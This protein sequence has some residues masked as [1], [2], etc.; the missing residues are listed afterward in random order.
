MQEIA[1]RL[2]RRLL[3]IGVE[4]DDTADVRL[5]KGMLMGFS[6]MVIPAGFI[7]GFIYIYFNEPVA[8]IFPLI[9]GCMTI[10]SIAIYALTG[11]YYRF[12]FVQ[13]LM[14]LVLPFLLLLA[15]GGFIN[16]SAVIVWSFIS[17]LG[18]LVFS[19]RRWALRWFIA[20]IAVVVVSGLLQPYLRPSNNL[21]TWLVYGFFVMN[22]G[23]I[24]VV[25][26]VLF[27]YFIGQKDR[28]LQLLRQEQEKTDTLLLNVL[29][30]E[31]AAILKY[32][33]RLIAD[34]HD[35]ASVMFADVVGFTSLSAELAPAEMVEMLNEVFSYF[36]SLVEKYGLEKIRTIGDNYMVGSGVPHPRPDHA[37]ALVR[38]ALEMLAYTNPD[39]EVAD[40]DSHVANGSRAA[41][42]RLQFRIGINSGPMVA[43]VIGRRKF[44]Y[45]LWGDPV[46]VASRMESHGEPGKI[47]ITRETYE[48][49]KDDFV[50]S[51]RGTIFVKG[52]GAMETWYVIRS[53]GVGMTR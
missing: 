45:D 37:H 26:F 15:L 17:P 13:L 39:G 2:F 31:I 3:Q 49:I 35:M 21:P 52:K 19:E 25:T 24:A 46:N 50:C 32:E 51:S 30:K 28:A 22:I 14:I 38:M 4:P 9:Y 7:W 43:G 11:H 23:T 44:H 33:N 18:A 34:H 47:Q 41:K 12:R 16:S 5:I 29:P 20:F 1:S 6:V 53:R 40:G 10:L 27:F 48:L 8:G 42:S 36:D